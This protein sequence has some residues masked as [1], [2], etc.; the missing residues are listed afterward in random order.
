MLPALLDIREIHQRLLQIFPE[1]TPQRSYCT[2]EMAARA[3]FV[4]LYIGAVEG[5]GNLRERAKYMCC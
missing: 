5:S 4:M 2:R 1:G 3:V